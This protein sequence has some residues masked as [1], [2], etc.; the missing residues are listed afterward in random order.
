M[1]P[2]VLWLTGLPGAGKSTLAQQ[3]VAAL[4]LRGIPT[5][6]LD[7]DWLRVNLFPE[8]GFSAEDRAQNVARTAM[9]A[10][11]LLNA[12]FVPVVAL[13]SPYR[14]GREQARVVM[15]TRFV[16]VYV[17]CPPDVCAQR[18]PKG[19]WARALRGEIE[20][21]TG[22]DAPYEVPENPEVTV[23]TDQQTVEESV[24]IIL[25]TLKELNYIC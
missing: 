8:L 11:L 16:E 23:H 13:V 10:R 21:F 9:L 17:D 19:M 7:G 22:L 12:G 24:N 20:G 6:W 5:I 25:A 15:G 4:H 2:F 14:T 18:D 1:E 3:L